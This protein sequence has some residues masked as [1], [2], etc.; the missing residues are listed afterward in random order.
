MHIDIIRNNFFFLKKK[1]LGLA[2]LHTPSFPTYGGKGQ[3]PEDDHEFQANL[4]S[5][6][7][8]DQPRLHNESFPKG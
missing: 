8:L 2:Q 6:T 5:M 3:R 1:Q 7:F 4:I